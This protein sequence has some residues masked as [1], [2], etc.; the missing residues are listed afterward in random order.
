MTDRYW[1][2]CGKMLYNYYIDAA[3]PFDLRSAPKLFNAL[4]DALE[5]IAKHLGVEFLWHYLDDFITVGR[6]GTDDCAFQLKLLIELCHRLGVPLALEKIEGPNTCLPF[7]GIEIDSIAQELHLPL[8]KLQRVRTMLTAWQ[9]KKKC[10]KQELQ[11]LAGHL[12]HAASIVRPGGTFI[13]RL[14]D[15]ISTVSEQHHHLRISAGI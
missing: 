10:T 12:Q 11:S 5:W 4:A 8:E 3:L 1:E 6:P 14:F 7:L 15:L 2:W 13:R 9:Y